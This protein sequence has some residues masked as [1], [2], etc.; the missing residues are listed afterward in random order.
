MN[1]RAKPFFLFVAHIFVV[2][3]KIE[4]ISKIIHYIRILPFLYKPLNLAAVA[5]GEFSPY[6]T[7]H[8]GVALAVILKRLGLVFFDGHN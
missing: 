3:A 8:Y 4:K 2:F 1:L 6:L 7:N 5:A